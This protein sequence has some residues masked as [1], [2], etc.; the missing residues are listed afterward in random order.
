MTG[1]HALLLMSWGPMRHSSKTDG[2]DA[3]LDE[4]VLEAAAEN[5]EV[6]V[7]KI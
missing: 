6:S 5:R 1:I 2:S 4:H 7:P 3:D